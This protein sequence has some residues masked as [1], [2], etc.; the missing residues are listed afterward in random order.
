M[1]ALYR[2]TL[3]HHRLVDPQGTFRH[4]TYIWLSSVDG[5]LRLANPRGFN[6]L[7]V[8]WHLRPG[9]SVENVVAEVHNTY[10]QKHSYQLAG[11]RGAVAKEL[12]VSPFLDMDGTYDIR[13]PV[14]DERLSIMV[15]LTQQGRTS[16]VATLRGE[17]VRV[18][19]WSRARAMW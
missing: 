14:P 6:P 18:T 10:G 1:K 16:L 17:R 11:E 19:R 3:T 15:T 12:Y 13:V 8:Y 5:G 4:R 9:G 7:T 2:A